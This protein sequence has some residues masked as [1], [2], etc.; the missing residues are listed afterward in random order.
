MMMATI[1][2]LFLIV[3]RKKIYIMKLLPG[4]S[5]SWKRAVG[6]TAFKTKVSK[7]TGIPMSKGGIERKIGHTILNLFKI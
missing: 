6:I 2:C 7:T 5:F 1:P 3:N 4:L